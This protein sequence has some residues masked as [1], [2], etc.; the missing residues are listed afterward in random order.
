M[1]INDERILFNKRHERRL[2]IPSIHF[3]PTMTSNSPS[4][5]HQD[6]Q[7]QQAAQY[8]Q[9]CDFLL[10]AT[11]AGFSADSNLPTYADVAR[12]PI[13][14]QQGIDYSDLCRQSCPLPLFYGFW[15][16][17]FNA[18]QTATPH[19][20]YDVLKQWCCDSQKPRDYY[21]YSS[22]VDGHFRRKGFPKEKIHELHG[23][24]D[25][26]YPIDENGKIR[27]GSPIHLDPQ[28]RFPVNQRLEL[29]PETIFQDLLPTQTSN[30]KTKFRPKV[31]MFDDGWDVHEAMGLKQSSDRYQAWEEQMETQMQE[32][33][34]RKLVVLELGCGT[35]VPSVR[36]ECQDVI[37]DTAQRV[38]T[39]TT[40][41]HPERIVHIRINPQEF[42]IPNPPE[43][44][45][46]IGIPGT[47]LSSLQAMDLFMTS[48]GS[49]S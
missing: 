12:N 48:G 46:A 41:S 7:L 26:W 17:C 19:P 8:I 47:A 11:G 2:T 16:S 44:T 18:Y 23:A 43:G 27:G 13:Y 24:I 28:Y 49:E 4:P 39:T 1:R 3:L 37:A 42:Q 40:T 5:N 9:E 29:S 21:V 38:K 15:G 25:T 32:N 10:I 31:L 35:R 6:Q 22:N 30:T 34:H 33:D 45:I 20:G 14:E 36:R